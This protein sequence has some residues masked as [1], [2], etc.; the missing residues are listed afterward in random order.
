MRR[1]MVVFVGGDNIEFL[2]QD[3]KG[4]EKFIRQLE[5]DEVVRRGEHV[6]FTRNIIFIRTLE[7]NE[8]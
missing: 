3:E 8:F 5:H 6:I 2:F 7:K 1:V 4:L